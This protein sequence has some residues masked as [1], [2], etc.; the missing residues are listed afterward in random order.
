MSLVRSFAAA[1]TDAEVRLQPLPFAHTANLVPSSWVR[2]LKP[3]TDFSFDEA[4]LLC[5][6]AENL[7]LAWVPDYGE[8][9]LAADEFCS[10]TEN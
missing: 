6:D 8:L 4:L 2:L 7:W 10:L 3:P 9:R 5:R 1:R